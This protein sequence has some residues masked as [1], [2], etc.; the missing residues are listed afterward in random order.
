MVGPSPSYVA[1]ALEFWEQAIEPHAAEVRIVLDKIN[2]IVQQLPYLYDSDPAGQTR[3][4]T[5][6]D[7]IGMLRYARR[8][9]PLNA[10][11]LRNLGS[12]ADE[13]GH[14][15]LAL[16]AYAA[17]LAETHDDSDVPAEVYMRL[18]RIRARL[19]DYEHA[20][21]DLRKALVANVTTGGYSPFQY[22]PGHTMVALSSSLAASGRLADAVDT[23]RTYLTRIPYYG[24]ES[25]IQTGFAL[26]V[27]YDRDEQRS[28]AFEM[29][30]LLISANQGNYGVAAYNAL[31][32]LSFTPAI[33]Q[34]YY[35]ALLYESLDYLAEARTEWSAYARGGGEA[36]FADRALDHV[37]AID[38]MLSARLVK[39]RAAKSAA[40]R[41]Q[42]A[43]RVSVP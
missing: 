5:I 7:G 27:S 43:P 24:D 33:D 15:E 10:D 37:T 20:V 22:S 40:K 3:Q 17:Y 41:K 8:L 2:L 21:H 4:Q 36:L 16:E 12:L 13:G 14:A 31:S 39:E 11:V 29:L 26:A 19:R 35:F 9:T 38:Q 34:H 30:D 32:R 1:P 6:D 18:G 28:N 25:A 42:L 23:L